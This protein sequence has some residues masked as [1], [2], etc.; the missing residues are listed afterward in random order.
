[1]GQLLWRYRFIPRNQRRY[2]GNI[3]EETQQ[4][5]G[6]QGQQPTP[7]VP[8]NSGSNLPTPN[9]QKLERD[10]SPG[11]LNKRSDRRSTPQHPML[12]HPL[13]SGV[14]LHLEQAFCQSRIAHL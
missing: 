8:Q 11:G 12:S 2:N 9:P 4:G 1:M 6:T 7:Q 5:Q 10:Q 14:Q 13:H 3:A